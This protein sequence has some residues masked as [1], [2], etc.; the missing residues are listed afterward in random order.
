MTSSGAPADLTYFGP[1]TAYAGY[2]EISS[3]TLEAAGI[4]I[5]SRRIGLGLDCQP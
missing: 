2:V 1:N 3:G 5:G 4:E